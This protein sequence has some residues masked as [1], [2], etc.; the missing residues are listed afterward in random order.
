MSG[1][2]G[3]RVMVRHWQGLIVRPAIIVLAATLVGGCNRPEPASAPLSRAAY[4]AAPASAWQGYVAD[5]ECAACHAEIADRYAGHPM[6]RSMS[7]NTVDRICPIGEAHNNPFTAGGFEY[8]VTPTPR[9]LEHRQIRRAADGGVV[10]EVA[11]TPAAV[12]GSGKHGQS[13]LVRR[14]D[15]LFMSPITWYPEREVWDLSPG[16]ERRNSEF[17]RPVVAECV[18]CH[19]NRVEPVAESLNGY[20]DP[21]QVTESIGCQRCHGP[22]GRHVAERLTATRTAGI[23]PTI[24]NPGRLEPALREAVC[25]Q[26]HL[27]GLV[28][29]ERSG[30]SWHDFRPGQPLEHTMVAFVGAGAAADVTGDEAG[31]AQTRFGGHVEQMLASRCY[32]GSKGA[33]GCTSCHDPH[34][35]PTPDMRVDF[36]R[37]K[38]VACHAAGGPQDCG[39]AED[40][41]SRRAA[42]NDCMRCHMPR[43]PNQVRHTAITDH[44]ILRRAT[45]TGAA[46]GMGP[47]GVDVPDWAAALPLRA[48]VVGPDH[49]SDAQQRRDMA[50]GLLMAKGK[51]PD[52]VTRGQLQ[53]AA[54][55]LEASLCDDPLDDAG[56]LS[57]GQIRVHLDDLGN[58]CGLFQQV[59]AE[60]PRSELAWV[61]AAQALTAMNQPEQALAS[62]RRALEINPHMANYWYERGLLEGRLGR[63]REALR[64]SREASERFPTSMGARQLL[65]QAH[66][67]V[68]DRPA[69]EAAFEVMRLFQPPGFGRVDEWYRE[70]LSR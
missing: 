65:I 29:V 49:R 10:V 31:T 64:V 20:R 37:Q 11:H 51:R 46:V 67:Q 19:A 68:G 17:F 2:P 7:A 47:A 70:Q 32:A 56:R 13:F 38:C 60:H 14:D 58:A 50:L 66:L 43:E 40:D 57:L 3:S 5:T 27:S 25:Q 9:G 18:F 34:G 16:Y 69:A 23:D 6:G 26:C 12:V 24:V 52:A 62:W 22:G 28:R 41:T 63:W 61:W 48:V 4:D 54:A 33:L 30:R 36:F 35:R 42:E 1:P 8:A 21:T 59:A 55:W 15:R 44:R 53:Q 45:G 39:L